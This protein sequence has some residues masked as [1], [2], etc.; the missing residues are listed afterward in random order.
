M[1]KSIH[2]MYRYMF[3]FMYLHVYSRLQ[4]LDM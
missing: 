4:K 3:T 2:L 1:H